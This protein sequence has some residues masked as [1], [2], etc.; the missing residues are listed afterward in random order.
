MNS[1]A[2][3]YHASMAGEFFVAAQLQRL[4]VAASVTYGNAKSADVIAL[5]HGTCKALVVEVKTSVKGRWPVGNRVPA[6]SNKPWVFVYLPIKSNEPPEYF[7]MTQADI[8]NLL[9]PLEKEYF[10]KYKNRHNEEYGEKP[11]I[12]AMTRELALQYNFKDNWNTILN[13]LKA[14]SSP[15]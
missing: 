1:Q 5:S 7:V 9:A 2:E 3:K 12:A 4:Q 6:P 15:T 13:V 11:G 14:E 8:H 10:E